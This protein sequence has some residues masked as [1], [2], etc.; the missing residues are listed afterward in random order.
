MELYERLLGTGCDEHVIRQTGDRAG[1]A[2]MFRDPP[3][4]LAISLVV[5]GASGRG[6]AG[7]QPPQLAGHYLT[8]GRVNNR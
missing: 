2:D 3:P 5:L 4:K 1:E 7:F 6:G 8:E